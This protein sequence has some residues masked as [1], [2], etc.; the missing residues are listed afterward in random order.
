[1]KYSRDRG[2]YLEGRKMT[3]I[4]KCFI[5]LDLLIYHPL[6]IPGVLKRKLLFKFYELCI[7]DFEF[8]FVYFEWYKSFTQGEKMLIT[9]LVLEALVH[10]QPMKSLK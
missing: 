2:G 8:L 4:K 1:M 9:M 5:S 6:E 10:Q 3:K 7:F